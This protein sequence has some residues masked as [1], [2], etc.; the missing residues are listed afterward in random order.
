MNGQ[1]S[2]ARHFESFFRERRPPLLHTET[3]SGCLSSSLQSGLARN[4][5]LWWLRTST[6]T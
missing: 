1:P 3:L 5:A 6:A 2:L 4:Q